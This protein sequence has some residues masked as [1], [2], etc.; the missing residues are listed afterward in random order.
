MPAMKRLPYLL[1][2]VAV[3]AISYVAGT[4][5]S[6]RVSGENS[7]LAGKALLY[8]HC[9]MHPSFKS[10]KPGDAP[11]CGMKLV[12]VFAGEEPEDSS[13]LQPTVPGAVFISAD[14]R[15]LIGVLTAAVEKT[16]GSRKVRLLG[17]ATADETRVFKI[18][19]A[20][21][22]VIKEIY[23][24]TVGSFVKKGQPLA[25]YY[26]PDIYQAEQGYLIAVSSDR[27]RSNLQVQVTES[28]LQF[29]GMSSA[30]IERLKETGALTENIA[31]CSPTSG[32]IVAREVYPELVFQKG[33]EL[34]RIAALDRMWVYADVFENEARHLHPGAQ[35]K[36][37]QTQTGA[38]FNARVS[39][40]L[41]QF[42]PTTRTLKVRMEVD[43]PEYALRPDMFVDVEFPIAYPDAL[44]VPSDAV[45]DS[46]RK[47]TV[48]V[49]RDGGV[50]E[51]RLVET[52]WR[53][54]DRVQIVSGLDE[55]AR[56]VVSG[57]F[58]ID[59]E[60]RMKFSEADKPPASSQVKMVKDPVCGMEIDSQSSTTLKTIYK[61]VTYY[62]CSETCKK[63]FE[64]NPGKYAQKTA[65]QQAQ[66]V[67]DLVCGMDVDPQSPKTLKA[68]YK[69]K[70]YYFCSDTC[71]KSF[72]ANPEKYIQKEV[73]HPHMNNSHM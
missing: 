3:I 23:P 5:N 18:K 62:F 7:G 54:G 66:P 49:E 38:Q 46:G 53:L 67:K 22:G 25:S 61:G 33:E 32:F 14:K 8:Y 17:R 55:G 56:V 43:N 45:I 35:A 47:R 65:P 9:P 58:L 63:S 1:T 28:R 15:Q 40:V 51:P 31:L 20:V 19:A 71:K 69:G 52:G 2:L 13:D 41:P 72:E 11:C 68:Q 50:Y 73:P 39:D 59:S 10:D 37:Y 60:S 6:R 29:L 16:S 34:F 42:D 48:Y 64:A 4:W 21:D 12:P 26:A 70:T 27:Y 24:E 36:V 30:Q 44:T 57:N